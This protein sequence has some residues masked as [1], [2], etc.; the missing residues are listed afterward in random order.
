MGVRA[1][2]A[3]SPPPATPAGSRGL[4]GFGDT[5][6]GWRAGRR[7]RNSNAP[8]RFFTS[9]GQPLT[10]VGVAGGSMVRT[11]LT[12]KAS[13]VGR[14]AASSFAFRWEYNF[15]GFLLLCLSAGASSLR[16]GW[17]AGARN[18][19]AGGHLLPEVMFMVYLCV[20]LGHWR[21]RCFLRW[22]GGC[23]RGGFF[24]RRRPPR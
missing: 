11:F 13:A 7:A 4:R 20:R 9:A 22:S 5:A 6:C 2:K 16:V 15:G 1:D 12:A 24:V 10:R 17:V 3:I 19:W 8:Q 14:D 18:G 23:F 21:V